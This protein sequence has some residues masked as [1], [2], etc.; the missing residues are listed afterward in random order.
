MKLQLINSVALLLVLATA[1]TSFV[2][3]S[4]G[5]RAAAYQVMAEK[6]SQLTEMVKSF[7]VVSSPLKTH[8]EIDFMA[9]FRVAAA[10][11][12]CRQGEH[13]TMACQGNAREVEVSQWQKI[14][15]S[16]LSAQKP[17]S[18]L[19][20]FLWVSWFPAARNLL[21]AI[22]VV[23]QSGGRMALAFYYPLERYYIKIKTMQ[24]PIAVYLCV[25]IGIL[26]VIAFYSFRAQLFRPMDR[27]IRTADS[28]VDESGVPFLTWE[29]TDELGQLAASMQQMLVRIKMDRETM[30][31][32][33]ILLEEA[34]RKLIATREEM[35]RTE[36]FSSVGRLAAGLAHEIGNPIGIVQGYLSLL[37]ED[38][39]IREKIDY[40]QR[41]EQ[42]LFRIN[43]LV[44]QLLDFSRPSGDG[45]EVVDVHYIINEV[46]E[47]LNPQPLMAGITIHLHLEASHFM[48]YAIG[49]QLVQVLINSLI[50]AAD[51]IR[52]QTTGGKGII[53]IQTAD[54]TLEHERWL[55]LSIAD[56]GIGLPPDALANA[57]DPFFTTKP[58]GHGTGLGLSVSYAL[59]NAMGGHITLENRAAG[60]A[61]L[62]IRLPLYQFI[63]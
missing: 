16:S 48:I 59:I 28:Y 36:K 50:N 5:L 41:A 42:E 19:S 12:V 63:A 47:L 24:G 9:V 4:F 34:N 52:A 43:R 22:P 61:I 25:N 35:V 45:K 11:A 18:Q 17:Q 37:Q 3:H 32:H 8:R 6:E 49:P 23:D 20:G 39:N 7:I 33:V 29:R 38:L 56:T 60:G 46:A 40:C 15:H 44:R 27:L 10:S 26:L 14:V 13:G 51:A 55:C 53:T 58:P 57:F 1:L 21:V 62:V 2:V 31:R 30:R 54:A